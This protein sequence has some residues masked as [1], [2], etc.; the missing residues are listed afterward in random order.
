MVRLGVGISGD[1]STLYLLIVLGILF[2]K[3]KGLFKGKKKSTHEKQMIKHKAHRIRKQN[4]RR[5][6]FPHLCHL[7]M[8]GLTIFICRSC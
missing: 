8:L 7:A 4:R 1:L 6:Q 5:A 3:N 2:T